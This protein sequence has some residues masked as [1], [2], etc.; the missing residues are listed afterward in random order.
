MI[1]IG[2]YHFLKARKMIETSR[3][4]NAWN[5]YKRRRLWLV[6]S[7]V[8]FFVVL[9]LNSKVAGEFAFFWGI[10]FIIFGLRHSFFRC[11]RC[12]N[13]FFLKFPGNNSF[14]RHCLHCGLP[15]WSTNETETKKK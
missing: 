12:G 8:S 7:I 11:P 10:A 13:F 3:F 1:E 6:G 9:L 4:S 15:K 2:F 5:D 14:A